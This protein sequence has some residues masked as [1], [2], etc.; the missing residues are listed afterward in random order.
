MSAP[1]HERTCLCLYKTSRDLSI[2]LY[3]LFLHSAGCALTYVT[4]NKELWM[5]AATYG[6]VSAFGKSNPDDPTECHSLPVSWITGQNIALIP[7][8]TTAMK[9]FPMRKGT[10][11]G[12]IVGGFGGGAMV[13]N[14]IQTAIVNPDNVKVIANPILSMSCITLVIVLQP[15]TS[16]PEEGY[17]VD[18][19]LLDRVPSLLLILASIYLLMGLLGAIMICQPP[20]DWVVRRTLPQAPYILEGGF[21]FTSPFLSTG[22][23][24][25][26]W[27][28]YFVWYSLDQDI[29]VSH[30][31]RVVASK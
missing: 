13:F 21:F 14:Q 2:Q 25:F 20:E 12:I 29:A 16:G 10:A 26:L 30:P 18:E 27:N 1:Y 9:W 24:L 5:V 11:M 19:A 3:F 4:I 7:T 8:L 17:F 15:V 28:I 22:F 6:F 31:N 23:C